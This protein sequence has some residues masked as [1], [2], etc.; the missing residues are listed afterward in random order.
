MRRKK[1]LTVYL[2]LFVFGFLSLKNLLPTVAEHAHGDC[3]ELGHVHFY[4]L[5][6]YEQHLGQLKKAGPQDDQAD[7][8]HEAKSVSS[9]SVSP[10]VKFT[11]AQ[12]V[13]KIVFELVF[14]LANGF[15]SPYLEPM[16]KPPRTA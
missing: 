14:A 8:C 3:A 15:K 16:R 1:Q 2:L 10:E 4:N 6:K 12:P 7:D 9:Y 11:F 5:F 13:H